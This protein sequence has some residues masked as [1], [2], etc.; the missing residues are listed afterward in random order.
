MLYA[1]HLVVALSRDPCW[2][3]MNHVQP[4][5][6]NPACIH[7]R[8][9]T[10]APPAACVLQHTCVSVCAPTPTLHTPPLQIRTLCVSPDGTLMLSVDED[11]RALLVNRK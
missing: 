4:T 6:Q 10:T 1:Q 5:V 3:D 2:F 11:G 9:T 8:T 7:P